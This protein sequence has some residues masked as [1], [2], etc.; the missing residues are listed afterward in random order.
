MAMTCFLGFSG[1]FRSTIFCAAIGFLRIM[2]GRGAVDA[3]K[4]SCASRICFSAADISYLSTSSDVD[5]I[6]R[7]TVGTVLGQVVKKMAHV[8]QQGIYLSLELGCSAPYAFFAFFALHGHC[9]LT[10]YYNKHIYF[11]NI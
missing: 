11:V 10:E 2:C 8:A 6:N 3:W 9:K 5:E 4:A 7:I 1:Y